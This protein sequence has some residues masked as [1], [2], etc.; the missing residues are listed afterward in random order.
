MNE[1]QINNLKMDGWYCA[2]GGQ[3][4]GPMRL[5]AIKAD[6][7]WGLERRLC[8]SQLSGLQRGVFCRFFMPTAVMLSVLR[9]ETRPA[10]RSSAQRRSACRYSN[11]KR[12]LQLKKMPKVEQGIGL[13]EPDTPY[14]RKCRMTWAALIKAV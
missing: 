7:V 12:G 3:K 2:P 11:K 8:S 10:A 6:Q 13:D 14:R 1:K 5:E 9:P 4:N